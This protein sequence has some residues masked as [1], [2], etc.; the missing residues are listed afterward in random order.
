M[1]HTEIEHQEPYDE[2]GEGRVEPPANKETKQMSGHA[3]PRSPT[4]GQL[5]RFSLG[6]QVINGEFLPSAAD[7]NLHKAAKVDGM[8]RTSGVGLP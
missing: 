6:R 5:V 8:F 7:S 3:L 4:D 1:K 2:A